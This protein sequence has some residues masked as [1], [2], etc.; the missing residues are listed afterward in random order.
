MTFGVTYGYLAIPE[1]D[2]LPT[3]TKV[4]L[5]IDMITCENPLRTGES[6]QEDTTM[7]VLTKTAKRTKAAVEARKRKPSL[8]AIR[9]RN[10]RWWMI[11]IPN[12]E[13]ESLSQLANDTGRPVEE[14]VEL[15]LQQF[16]YEPDEV[17][18]LF[19]RG[20]GNDIPAAESEF[21]SDLISSDLSVEEMQRRQKKFRAADSDG[22]WAM[23]N[24]VGIGT[25]V[26]PEHVASTRKRLGL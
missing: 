15:A 21:I 22:K 13:Y 12:D 10:R 7:A 4:S 23:L 26:K 24:E 25:K 17:D 16:E 3:V 2:V 5:V 20:D 1:I 19:G 14:L 11:S 6:A 8:S 9:Q 18:L